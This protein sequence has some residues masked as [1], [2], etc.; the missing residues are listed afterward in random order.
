MRAK[1]HLEAMIDAKIH[2]GTLDGDFVMGE[3]SGKVAIITGAS[4]PHG[5]GRAIARRFARANASLFL[6]ADRTQEYLEDTVEECKSNGSDEVQSAIIDLG[7]PGQPEA[8]IEQARQAFGRVDILI[9]NAALRAPYDFG[10]YTRSTF[11]RLIAVNLAAPFFASQAVVPLMRTQ[12]G[13]RIIHVT[14]Q[15]AHVALQQRA[16]YGLTKAALVH[17]TKSMALELCKYNI[18]VN[19]LCPGPIAT[20][21]LRDMGL[22]S[23][24][25]LYEAG[26]VEAE[27]TSWNS[28]LVARVPMGR[29]GKVD[30]IADV[31][32]YLAVESPDFLMGQEIVVDGGYLI[33]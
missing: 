26:E 27:D 16:L 32:F 21:P 20:Q 13:G 9:N 2:T 31:A 23:M 3:L 30:E 22:Q 18:I 10:D 17:L 28:E 5:I 12:G 11:D 15:L 19:A 6:V 4:T 33:Q 1:V 25:Q 7:I 24:R 14:S 8:M 29:L